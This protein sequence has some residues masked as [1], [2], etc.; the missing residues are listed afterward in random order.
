ML[1][2]PEVRRQVDVVVGLHNVK[3]F[4]CHHADPDIAASLP[5]IDELV[6][7]PDAVVVTHWR[8]EALLKHYGLRLP[9]WRIEEHQWHLDLGDRRLRFLTTPY[10]HFPG[11]FVTF[12]EATGTL[13]SSDLFGGFSENWTLYAQDE[14]YFEQMR[15]FHEHYMPSREIL[16]YTLKRLERLPIRRIAPQHGSII[17]DRFVRP[18]IEALKGLECGLYLLTDEMTDV[19]RLSRLQTSLQDVAEALMLDRDFCDIVRHLNEIV[20]RYLP[21]RS[22][23][24]FAMIGQGE[25]LA[26]LSE[27][28]YHGTRIPVPPALASVLESRQE[29]STERNSS[30]LVRGTWP[31]DR[32]DGEPTV[33]VPLFSPSDRKARGAAVIRLDRPIEPTVEVEK[34]AAEMSV[35]LQVAVAREILNHSREMERESMYQLSIRDPLT[36]LFTR[37]YMVDQLQR[38]FALQDRGS[39]GAVSLIMFDVDSFKAINDSFGHLVGDRVL[40]ATSSLVLTRTRPADVAVRFGGD[41]FAIFTVGCDLRGT[42]LMAERMRSAVAEL[43]IPELQGGS[44]SVSAGIALRARGELADSLIARADRALYSAKRAGRNRVCASE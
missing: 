8:A 11:A 30:S 23:E 41:E 33:I 43:S 19:R 15:H 32:V 10:C 37:S 38:L 2:W 35:P 24:F 1:T 14:Q 20:G 18:I 42:S 44:V 5:S 26:L 34:L 3:Y 22:M 9:F 6:T 36:G 40:V 17:P 16:G 27:G 31:F 25:T 21:V 29:E 4:V 28:R 39:S 12:D 13:F 7:R